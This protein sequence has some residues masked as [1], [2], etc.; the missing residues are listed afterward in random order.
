MSPLPLAERAL[1]H[2]IHPAKIVTDVASA[3]ASLFL[4]SSHALVAG[5]AIAFLPP[6]AAS[7]WLIL[8]ADLGPYKR[9]AF[10]KY[11]R[12]WMTPGAQARRM[13]GFGLMAWAAWTHSYPLMAFGV[14]IIV[15]A[16]AAGLLIGRR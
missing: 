6:V 5:I 14:A 12:K 4:F 1:Y 15:H 3:L 10:G 13:G 8:R 7:V 9:S 11:V 2:Q 16:W